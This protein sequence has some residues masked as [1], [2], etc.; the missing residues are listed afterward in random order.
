MQYLSLHFGPLEIAF[1]DF[2]AETGILADGLDFPKKCGDLVL[3]WAANKNLSRG[4]ALD[5]GCAVGRSSFEI[6]REFQQVVAI[7]L[8]QTFIDMAN[9]MKEQ[10]EIK[11]A[12]RV[13]GDI[14][15]TAVARID[16]SIDTSRCTFLQVSKL[17]LICYW[18]Y[19]VGFWIL[20]RC[21]SWQGAAVSL[22]PCQY[23]KSGPTALDTLSAIL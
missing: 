14:S 5:L 2:L 16:E 8:S 10:K 18:F 1:A 15:E 21:S 3:K 6:A 13:E 12:L 4:R 7:D 22:S 9:K 11:Y 23:H 20:V 17:S 19:I